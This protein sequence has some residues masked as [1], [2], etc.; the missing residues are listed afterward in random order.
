M[1]VLGAYVAGAWMCLSA[2]PVHA[3]EGVVNVSYD[4]EQ[5][6]LIVANTSNCTLGGIKI[7]YEARVLAKSKFKRKREGGGK[8][9]SHTDYWMWSGAN[10]ASDAVSFVLPDPMISVGIAP[11]GYGVEALR[12]TDVTLLSRVPEELQT[13][14]ISYL[15]NMP[16]T[17]NNWLS[18]VSAEEWEQDVLKPFELSG[19]WGFQDASANLIVEKCSNV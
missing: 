18:E 3:G 17:T 5:D 12:I 14:D 7:S 15:P 10:A 6:R 4:L 8:D 19:T 2:F 16:A 1:R 13:L 11:G 9:W